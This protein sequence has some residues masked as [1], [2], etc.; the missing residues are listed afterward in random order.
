MGWCLDHCCIILNFSCRACTAGHLCIWNDLNECLLHFQTPTSLMYLD[1]AYLLFNAP[2]C[3]TRLRVKPSCWLITTDIK[4][5][6]LG[7][8]IA[9]TQGTSSAVFLQ[10]L[11]R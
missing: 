10:T 4:I 6:W 1:S 9:V 5:K 7:N 2:R 11:L 3:T 8:H